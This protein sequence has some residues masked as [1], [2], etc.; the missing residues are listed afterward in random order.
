MAGLEPATREPSSRWLFFAWAASGA[1]LAPHGVN[2]RGEVCRCPAG[3]NHYPGD[4]SQSIDLCISGRHKNNLAALRN[5]PLAIW[6]MPIIYSAETR[7]WANG[8]SMLG[9]RHRRRPNIETK[10]AQRLVFAVIFRSKLHLW[11]SKKYLSVLI[12]TLNEKCSR[13][14]FFL[15]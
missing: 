9:Q 14:V 11:I 7:H 10:L 4:D 2:N 6:A 8:V 5:K 12:K 15:L 3:R 13:Y 1:S